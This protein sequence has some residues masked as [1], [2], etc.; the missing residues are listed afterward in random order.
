[1]NRPSSRR[2]WD[3]S[4]RI[5]REFAA[6]RAATHDVISRT[7]SEHDTF[8]ISAAPANTEE[9]PEPS[10]YDA[11]RFDDSGEPYVD[12]DAEFV[13]LADLAAGE[14]AER[15][16][17]LETL[18]TAALFGPAGTG[19]THL[20]RERLAANPRYAVL[21]ATTGVA[22]INMGPGV[23]TVHSQLKF[24]DYSS[25]QRCFEEGWLMKRFIAL[26][27]RR[28]E[29]LVIDEIS[30]FSAESLDILHDAAD[31]A[32]AHIK[33]NLTHLNPVGLLL[34]GDACQLP[35]VEGRYFFHARCWPR[36]APN[37]TRLEKN[38]R[39]VDPL[40]LKA[41]QAARCGK[42]VE[43]VMALRKLGVRFVDTPIEDFDGTT[44]YPL[45][46][47]VDKRN[48]DMLAK[49]G[50][51]DVKFKR[52]LW[53]R[54]RG[55]WKNIPEELVLRETARVMVLVNEPQKFR[56]VNGDLGTVL[57]TVGDLRRDW[58]EHGPVD[59]I[60]TFDL[61]DDFDL[62]LCIDRESYKCAM[63]K[64]VR[65][66]FQDEPPS[67]VE[68]RQWDGPKYDPDANEE[69]L[70]EFWSSYYDYL[71]SCQMGGV[72]YFD[73]VQG[74]WVVG[75]VEY[76][77]VRLGYALTCHKVQGLTL[78]SVQ[79][80]CRNRMAGKPG[81]M[82]VALSRVRHPEGLVIVGNPATLAKRIVANSEVR[83]W[84]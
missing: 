65:K 69:A 46:N 47:Q 80:D 53:G 36:F 81:L 29:Y 14:E 77:P 8:S 22:A 73:P 71:D 19:K 76:M 9:V 5:A 49:I 63:R 33:E 40:F 68:V 43:C 25:L 26:A 52:A 21:T 18:N 67:G 12:D 84:M 62:P 72:S 34:C 7:F 56:Y 75:E 58:T 83:E 57:P 6:D 45:N 3:T 60:S 59:S 37:V 11:A 42:G 64:V 78:D 51:P 41:L 61:L 13:S 38:Y 10:E 24:F 20:V 32:R 31:A 15:E 27:R 44:L 54:E 48:A 28:V 50:K 79:V 1:M 39:Q 82:Y 70:A 2:L 35:P 55:E 30:M 74:A 4:R 66:N 17:N 23:T 16:R